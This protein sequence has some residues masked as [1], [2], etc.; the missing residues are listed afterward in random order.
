MSTTLPPTPSQTIGPFFR[1]GMEWLSGRAIPEAEPPGALTVT[2]RV[3][4]GDGEPVPDALV[5]AWQGSVFARSLTD[6]EGRFRFVT[7][8]PTPA[9]GGQAPHVEVSVFARG[10][11]QRLW[12]RLYFPDEAAANEADPLLGAVGDPARAATLVAVPGE[13]GGVV[14]D[15]RLQGEGE[16]VFFAW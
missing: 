10:L 6:A 5:E 3:L 2:G 8:K 15:V 1:F 12:T 4:D 7:V 13:D 16:T 9:A 14:F 11:L